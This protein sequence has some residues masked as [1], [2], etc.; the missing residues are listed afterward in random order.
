MK[1]KWT[2]KLG[3]L[4]LVL[5]LVTASLA[6]GT[7]AKYLTT[8]TGTDTVTVAAW[9]AKFG[10]DTAG[11]AETF[12]VDLFETIDPVDSGVQPSLLAPGTQGSFD[13]AYDTSG[14]QVA[15]N[16]T[17]TIDTAALANLTQ[18]KFYSDA[19]C[20]E[21]IPN[22]NIIMNT[23][24]GPAA[25]DGTG[26]K[27]VYWKWAFDGDDVADT[28]DGIDASSFAI[29]ITFTATQLDTYTP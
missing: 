18:L 14:T 20:S 22:G 2:I 27:T 4:V 28:A 7:F 13:V 6:T 24:F 16:V 11:T 26:T 12:D 19:L 29:T 25:E 15:R 21:E 1:K 8:Q 5:T 17:I 9:V 10:D 3:I 23:D